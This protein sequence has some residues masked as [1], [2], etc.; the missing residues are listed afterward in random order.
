MEDGASLGSI[1]P[2]EMFAGFEPDGSIGAA[3]LKHGE[4]HEVHK[5]GSGTVYTYRRALADI[6]II[7]TEMWGEYSSQ[8][9]LGTSCEPAR[10]CRCRTFSCNL[11][12]NLR[13]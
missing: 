9:Y 10:A 7:E 12:I 3:R 6:D 11:S 13:L 4:P 8:S 2:L 5:E 1:V